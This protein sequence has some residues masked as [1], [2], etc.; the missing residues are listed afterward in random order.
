MATIALSEADEER[1]RGFVR[2]RRVATGLL[3]AAAAVFVITLHQD[4]LLAYVNAA[5]EAAMVGALADWFA[6][7]ALFRHPMGIPIPHTALVPKKKDTFAHGLED[8][9]TGNFLT[10]EAARERYVAADVTRRLGVWLD[11]PAHSR[12]LADETAGL[13]ARA[14]TRVEPGDVRGLVEHSLV[15][16]L[17]A[18][19]VSPLAGALLGE[20]VDDG[21]HHSLVDIVVIEAHTWLVENPET[22]MAIIGER[23]PTWMPNWVNDIVADRLHLE[24]VTW[25]RDVRDNRGHRVRQ[26][27]DDLLRDLARDLQEDPATMARAETIKERLLTHPQTADTAMS[28]WEVTRTAL[29]RAL[30]EEHSVLR[31]RIA[32]ELRRLGERLVA[33]PELRARVDERVG[34]TVA[35]LVD[36]Y[37]AELAPIISQVIARWDGKEAAEKIELHV[38]RDLQFIRINGTVV[39]GLAGLVIHTVSKLLA[40]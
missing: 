9:V 6:V 30:E 32:K 8:F 11:D 3:I 40:P 25:I 12:R 35:D 34:D 7:T 16:R 28:V 2:M 20:V 23:A 38:G 5:A 17:V 21:I 24:A 22:F 15:P 4:G 19:P 14:L 27:L 13:L 36:T 33:E 39:G 26:A 10:G 18:E 31:E 1:R 37:G 29:Q